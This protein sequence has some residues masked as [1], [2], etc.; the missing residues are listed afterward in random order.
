M[1]NIPDDSI[2]SKTGTTSAL[3]SVLFLIT[4]FSVISINL[5]LL[6]I[7]KQCYERKPENITILNYILYML[8][9]TFC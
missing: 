2:K 4:P 9:F 5:I 6:K 7:R 1:L 8:L 3:E